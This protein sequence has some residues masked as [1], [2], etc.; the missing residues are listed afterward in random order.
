[1]PYDYESRHQTTSSFCVTLKDRNIRS[2]PT[3]AVPHLQRIVRVNLM[4]YLRKAV[5]VRTPEGLL[6]VRFK[7]VGFVLIRGT[8]GGKSAQRVRSI[9]QGFV[10]L[11]WDIGGCRV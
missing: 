10:V 11:D 5:V 8:I 9:R 1:M 2:L 7:Y 4:F 3:Y 6:V